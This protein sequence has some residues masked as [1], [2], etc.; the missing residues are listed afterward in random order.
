M[1]PRTLHAGEPLEDALGH[2][3]APEDER[4][5]RSVVAHWDGLGSYTLGEH[6]HWTAAQWAEHL[7]DPTLEHP[8]AADEH[9]IRSPLLHLTA[10]LHPAARDPT[11]ADWPEIA[12]RFA[13]NA[14]L[15]SPVDDQTCR[16]VA[17]HSR[18]RRL[19]LIANL[20]RPDGT[21]QPQPHP[22]LRHLVA[23]GRRIA[24]KLGL[25]P[26]RATTGALTTAP[27]LVTPT[28]GLRR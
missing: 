6:R 3:I 27:G 19:D 12:R 7:D 4:V 24:T 15:T 20:I 2:P 5:L 1:W 16:W 14:G 18:P 13:R 17:V 28:R 9:G 11:R 21:W 23:E 22:L 10:E 26:N 8:F 25:R